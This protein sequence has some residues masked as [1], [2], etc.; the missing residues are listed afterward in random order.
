MGAIDGKPTTK[1]IELLYRTAQIAT[2]TRAVGNR[3]FGALLTDAQGT[4]LLEQGN[5]VVTEHNDCAHA[6]IM[7]LMRA[8]HMYEREFLAT[9]S[10]YAS[11]EPCVMCSSALFMTNVGRLVYGLTGEMLKKLIKDNARVPSFGFPCREV[12]NTGQTEIE[13]VGP[14]TDATLGQRIAQ[15]HIGYWG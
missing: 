14:I 4:I 10:L 9:C 7:L 3:P 11:M 6:E 12:L 1:D 5:V 13:V 8:S 2:Q 15:D